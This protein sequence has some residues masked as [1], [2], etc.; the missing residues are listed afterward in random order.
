VASIPA[1]KAL[2]G[3]YR[4]RG[5]R[6]VSVTRED[7]RSEVAE[8][9]RQHE[10]DYPAFLDVDSSWSGATGLRLIPAFVVLDRSGRLAYRYVGRLAEGTRAFDEMAAVISEALSREH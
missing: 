5:L 10:M 1:V 6:V 4:T 2:E 7:D 9:A 3:R 8:A